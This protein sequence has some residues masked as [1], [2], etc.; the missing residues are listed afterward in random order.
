MRSLAVCADLGA[1][2]GG[3]LE[4]RDTYFAAPHGR[5][6]V[7]E[8][9]GAAACL[10]AYARAD[11]HDERESA[12]RIVELVDGEEMVSALS[13]V[14]GIRVI[15]EKRRELFLWNR[16]RIH[17]DEVTGLGQFIEIEAIAPADSDLSLEE[18]R[19]RRLRD[20]FSL[21]DDDLVPVSYCD[22]IDA[23]R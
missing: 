1:K 16:T 2:P 3:T 18:D 9:N 4:Q 12:Y 11:R 22:L 13:Q 17:L 10:I 21:S 7:R 14:I 6:K 8:E 15:V 23:S 20:A 5:L 19:V